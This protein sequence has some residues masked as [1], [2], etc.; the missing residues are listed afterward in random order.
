MKK[1]VVIIGSCIIVLVLMINILIFF[2]NKEI[3]NQLGEQNDFIPNIESQPKF[4]EI[5]E[6]TQIQGRVEIHHNG[7]IYLFNGEHFGEYGFEIEEYTRTNIDD[8][9]QKCIDYIS[10]KE[11][12]TS[13]VQ[14]GDLLI[15]TGDLKKIEY[16]MGENDFDTKGNPIIVLKEKDYNKMKQEAIRQERKTII[17][18]GE[19]FDTSTE[20]YLKYE[21]SDETYQL[22]FALKLNITQDTKII[23]ELMQGKKVKVQYKNKDV[24]LEE[25]EIEKIEVVE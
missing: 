15:C 20:I 22:P 11:Y 1:K 23:G 19:Y 17:T 3:D 4:K 16:G 12:D 2:N 13:Y 14:E 21:I 5:I 8:K 9:N 18:V 10:K 25:L 6:N 7:F 24:S